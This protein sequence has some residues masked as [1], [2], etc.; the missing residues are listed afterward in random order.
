MRPTVYQ[1]AVDGWIAAMLLMSPVLAAGLG[2]YLQLDGRPGDAM[3]LF[4]SGVA[5]LLVTAAFTVPCRYTMLD[6]ALSVR[7][8]IIFY[9]IPFDQIQNVQ[10]SRTLLSGPALS[11]RR[12]IVATKQRR[13]ILSPRER[14]EF[15]KD[16]EGSC[17]MTRT[18][19]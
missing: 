14:D 9:Q 10:P 2:A 17:K 8:G 18:K 19:S 3:I 16:L 5:T 11:M 15:I 1:S 6:D 4:I 13:Y 7:C 12:V